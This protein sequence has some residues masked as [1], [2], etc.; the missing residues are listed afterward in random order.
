MTQKKFV[1]DIHIRFKDIDFMGHINNAVYITYFEEGRKE[2]VH[3]VLEI[4]KPEDYS[5]ILAHISCDYLM[6]VK[7]NDTVYLEI[8]VE[9]IGNKRFDFAY[10]LLKKGIDGNEPIVCAKARSVQV[11]FDY[12][13]NVT[14]AIPEHIRELLSQYTV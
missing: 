4:M 5:F 13:Q 7:L 1:T 9:E 14:L 11:F 6:P 3:S 2:F 10:R 8:W 12:K